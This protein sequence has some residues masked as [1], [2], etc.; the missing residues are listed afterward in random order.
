MI[1]CGSKRIITIINTNTEEFRKNILSQNSSTDYLLFDNWQLSQK[2]IQ[3]MLGWGKLDQF[4]WSESVPNSFSQFDNWL[5]SHQDWKMGY[6]NYD[7][8]N[9]IEPIL[10]Q[11]NTN[12]LQSDWVYFFIPEILFV[13][14]EHW[15]EAHHYPHTTIPSFSAEEKDYIR[16]Q[17]NF[18]LQ[19]THHEYIDRIHQL[20]SHIEKGDLYEINYC[21]EWQSD[22]E[23]P[24]PSMSYFHLKKEMEA[25]FSC[26]FKLNNIHLLCNSP[27]RF[28]KKDGNTLISQP[29]KG[30]SSRF[31]H[32]ELDRKSKESLNNEKDR[33]ENIMT[34]DLVRNDLSKIALKG[35]VKTT[36]IAATHSFKQVHQ[37]VS[38]IECQIPPQTQFSDIL[39]ATFPM[40][41]MTGAP[42]I[43]AMN[44][45]EKLETMHR[46]IYSGS[47][48]YFQ[49]NGDFDFNVIIR[50]LIH[51]SQ[52][53]KSY[54]RAGGAITTASVAEAEWKESHLKAE[55]ILQF[56]Q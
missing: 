12:Q 23:L 5:N 30:T 56:F 52:N 2:G 31:E 35:S 37:L 15:V 8:K 42:K 32:P 27:E 6:I 9:Q 11:K 46:D 24:L 28:L 29:I 38:S 44:L 7:L 3:W 19:I 41:S 54:V 49:P 16:P 48:G 34:I 20:I 14:R 36:E 45:S 18:A 40:G 26:Y 55:K 43:N 13:A 1:H 39:K 17:L 21:I 51:F 4:I 53:N 47:V 22:K 25:P 10:L 33:S 50:S